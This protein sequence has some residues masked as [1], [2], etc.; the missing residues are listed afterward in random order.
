M[1]ID[2]DIKDNFSKK[3]KDKRLNQATVVEEILDNY[4]NNTNIQLSEDLV[5]QLSKKI[6][7]DFG[8]S[9]SPE[10]VIEILVKGFLNNTYK[11]VA[12]TKVV[13]KAQ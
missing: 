2:S 8:D 1:K 13:L 10:D 11:I 6:S 7:N 4:I 5:K 9:V 12:E 3:V